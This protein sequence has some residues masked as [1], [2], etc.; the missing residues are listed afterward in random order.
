M[1]NSKSFIAG[2]DILVPHHNSG[3]FDDLWDHSQS[4]E[5]DYEF[6]TTIS[7]EVDDDGTSIHLF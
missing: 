6:G 3:V 5:S 1:V 7:D 2:Y 4:Q